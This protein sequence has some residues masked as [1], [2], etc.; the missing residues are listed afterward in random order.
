MMREL[1]REPKEKIDKDCLEGK[2]PVLICRLLGLVPK[3]RGQFSKRPAWRTLSR[4]RRAISP[5]TIRIL[6]V[7]IVALLIPIGFLFYSGPYRDGLIDA[8]LEAMRDKGQLVAAAIGE[9]SVQATRTGRQFINPITAR[10]IIRRLS[11]SPK[12]RTRLFVIN[13]EQIADSNQLGK[14][15]TIQVEILA[16]PTQDQNIFDWMLG[17]IEL[18][19]DW[20]PRHEKLQP[21]KE[22][23][24]PLATHYEEVIR[25]FSGDMI[26]AVRTGGKS[27]LVLSVAIPVQHYRRVVGAVMLSQ[28]ATEIEEAIRDLRL[29]VLAIFAL[30]LVITTLLSFYL[31][32]TI[33]RPILHLAGAAER[34]RRGFG[35]ESQQIPDFSVR[36]DEIGDLSGALR[37]MTD[38]LHDRMDATE[39]FAADVSH[40]IKNPLTSLRSAVETAAR[41][42]DPDQQK[43][44]MSI[45]LED[46]QR[47]DR[48]IT[49]ISDAS[50]LDSELSREEMG[51]VEIGRMVKALVD[52]HHAVTENYAPTMALVADEDSALTIIGVEGRLVQVF[53]NL[54]G[55]AVSFSPEHGV[56]TVTVSETGNA[57][58]VVVEDQ[59]PGF[60]YSKREAIFDRF[61]TERPEGEKF[62]THSGLGLS[63]SKQIIEAHNGTI[64]AENCGDDSETGSGARFT[65]T[66]P[67]E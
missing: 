5:L 45:V 10:D 42:K 29:K 61:Y 26:G 65:V 34:V 27:G 51:K 14:G 1:A 44:L 20:I 56:I 2:S 57:V 24:S 63:I 37:E 28:D 58:K 25:A 43:Q 15:G 6:A 8:E 21:Y 49:D 33:A 11:N 64:T 59:G 39:R 13:G 19:V 23:A 16:P 52:V 66:L 48:L 67:I 47:L 31:A 55:N 22:A 3:L 38:A 12:L 54:L 50:R 7:N 46:V 17:L 32:G 4:R 36:G 18:S 9:T 41:L 62:G 53:R 30:A 60:P 35:R 40:E